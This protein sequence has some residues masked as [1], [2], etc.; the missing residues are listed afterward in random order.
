MSEQNETIFAPGIFFNKPHE[1]APDFIK[2]S[3]DFADVAMAIDFLK[4]HQIK[5]RIT[6]DLKKSKQGKLYLALNTWQ[7]PEKKEKSEEISK[8]DVPF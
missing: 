6:L 5:N 2:G 7:P 1:N 3:I 4:K 8:E